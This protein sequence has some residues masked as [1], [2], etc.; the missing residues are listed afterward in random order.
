M[1]YQVLALK[2]RPQTFDDVVGQSHV[3]TT[4][5]NAVLQDRVAHAIL[6][7]G[8]RGTG[9][10]TIARILAKAMN[11]TT[12]PTPAPCNQ[13]K[14]CTEII[15]GHSA[16][17]F[18]IDGASNNSVDQVRDLRENVTYM[19]AAAPYKIYIIDEVHM[20]STAAFN[21]LLKTLEEPP[22]HVL[23]IFAT[24]EVHKIPATILSRCQRHDLARIPLDAISGLL[25]KICAKEGFSVQDPGLDLIALEADGSVRDA[26]SLLDRMLS[27]S[28]EKQIS[29]AMVVDRLGVPDRRIMHELTQALLDRDVPALIALVDRVNDTGMDLK[30]FYGDLIG[31][32]RHMSV[33]RQCGPDHPAVNLTADEKQRIQA[34][35]TDLP[36]AY[37]GQ[38]LQVLLTDEDMVKR[39]SHT[40]IAIETVLFKLLQVRAGASIDRIVQQLDLLARQARSGE[41][42]TGTAE[43]GPS[44]AEEPAKSASAASVPHPAPAYSTP[45]APD[46]LVNGV[47]EPADAALP[48]APDIPRTWDG[49]LT[50]IETQMPSLHVLLSRGRIT[51]ETENA[52]ELHLSD[53][54]HFDRKRLTA[55]QKELDR[56]CQKFL[57]RTLTIH[58][59]SDTKPAARNGAGSEDIKARQAAV[60][61]PLVQHAQDLFNGEIINF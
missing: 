47:R 32:V 57:G 52:L 22:D 37:P 15:A 42:G 17:V 9:K 11:C 5:V 39:T 24:T 33:I 25:K 34:Q 36:D 27:A 49:F 16:D 3:T 13:C 28:P 23:F 60:Q 21:A 8:P 61:H 19:P 12:G 31:H 20:L 4:L 6:F 54:T 56:Q 45:A 59:A 41:T 14:S 38:L 29:H 51:S 43:A 35:V 50:R 48:Q 30:K 7:T 18:E 53:C 46:T 1:S 40:R 10:T 55:K 2:Y 26:L 58:V 44:P